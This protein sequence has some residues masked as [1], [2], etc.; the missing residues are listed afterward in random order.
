MAGGV[1]VPEPG[2][3]VGIAL[4]V[5]SAAAG[6][7]VA[8]TMVVCGEIGL[9]GEVRRIPQIERR[10]AEA[11]RLG[12]T[13]AV[14]PHATPALD[15]PLRLHRVASMAEALEAAAVGSR[16]TTCGTGSARDQRH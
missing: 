11:A 12:F 6:H 3:D 15:L 14:V 5:L 9:T 2:A 16:P 7:A 4:A 1:K 8:P 13:D 10:L